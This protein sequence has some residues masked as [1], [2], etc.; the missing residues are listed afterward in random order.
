MNDSNPPEASPEAPPE[1]SPYAKY[2]GDTIYPSQ[3]ATLR[4]EIERIKGML[5]AATGDDEASTIDKTLFEVIREC[6]SRDSPLKSFLDNYSRTF[7]RSSLVTNGHA[8][9][10]IR[11]PQGVWDVVDKTETQRDYVLVLR[12]ID[13]DWCEA[14][15]TRYPGAIDRRFLLEHILGI[16]LQLSY[17]PLYQVSYDSRRMLEEGMDEPMDPFTILGQAAADLQLID[18]SHTMQKLSTTEGESSK[19]ALDP[20]LRASDTDFE[21]LSAYSTWKA[22]LEFW[23]DWAESD[24]PFVMAQQMRTSVHDKLLAMAAQVGHLARKAHGVH[25]NWWRAPQY[26]GRGYILSPD[27]HDEFRR[28]RYGW[29][30]SNAFVSCCRLASNLCG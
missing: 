11:T 23:E 1:A 29:A 9:H 21:A 8:P 30:K 7:T 5:E 27:T 28:T 4:A 24:K 26:G 22:N 6:V 3:D 20:T 15:C 13:S 10:T 2:D 12:D 18:V 17:F 14:L 25:I 19:L 16:D